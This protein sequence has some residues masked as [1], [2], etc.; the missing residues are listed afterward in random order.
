MQPARLP[1]QWS[2]SI[3][4]YSNRDPCRELTCHIQAEMCSV[5]VAPIQGLESDLGEIRS[6]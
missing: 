6:H 4:I 5:A 2:I 3:N 1:I